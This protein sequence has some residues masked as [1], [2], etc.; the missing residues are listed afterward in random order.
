M[1]EEIAARGPARRGPA[2]RRWGRSERQAR[3][4]GRGCDNKAQTTRSS[5]LYLNPALDSSRGQSRR[6]LLDEPAGR[7]A[8]PLASDLRLL[9]SRQHLRPPTT[10]APPPAGLVELERTFQP[11]FRLTQSR[12][13]AAI[14]RRP[15]D[16]SRYRGARRQCSASERCTRADG[17][18]A[19]ECSRS[20]A[21]GGHHP[22]E[23]R[24]KSNA[25]GRSPG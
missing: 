8:P 17:D 16:A 23:R 1:S 12:P 24:T 19:G 13:A 3:E 5:S 6:H 25:R 22:D 10:S 4:R 21:E 2:R 7:H 18:R 9:G 20:S 11:D 14:V 15:P